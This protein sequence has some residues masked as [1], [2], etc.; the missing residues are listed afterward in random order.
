MAL[1]GG[2]RDI[3]LFR[4]INKELLHDIIEQ[5]VGY[6]KIQ[7]DK[8]NSNIYGESSNKTYYSPVLIPCL[9]YRNPQDTQSDQFGSDIKH[10]NQFA[11]LREDLIE[12]DVYPEIGDVILWQE[13]YYEA[14]SLIENQL[15]LGKAPEYDLSGYMSQFGSSWSILVNTVSIRPDKLNFVK[16][17]I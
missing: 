9:I 12:A 7:L 11:F 2:S 13:K 10:P 3:N 14:E 15:I 4:S 16:T 17:R 6:Y 5:Q 8:T 1:F